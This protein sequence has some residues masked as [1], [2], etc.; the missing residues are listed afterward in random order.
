M[1]LQGHFTPNNV[2]VCLHC[3]LG[4]TLSAITQ[5]EIF[6]DDV[7]HWMATSCL[8]LIAEKTELLWA[9]SRYSAEAQLG[10]SGLSVRFDTQVISASDHVC[11]LG[12]TI[13]SAISLDNHMAKSCELK[14]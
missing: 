3:Y 6:L 9:G 12:V 5:L 11:V 1:L 7:S 13:S 14:R 2:M 4:D 8:K 10:S